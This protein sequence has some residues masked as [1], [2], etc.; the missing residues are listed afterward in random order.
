MRT[1]SVL[2][3]LSS[4]LGA[5][6]V[7]AIVWLIGGRFTLVTTTSAA[8]PVKGSVVRL[9]SDAT[10]IHYVATTGTDDGDCSTPA[11]ACRTIQYAV[12]RAGEGDEVRIATGIYTGVNNYGGL[13]Q[14]VYI[15][16]TVTIRGGYTTTDWITSY[17]ISYPTTLDA[18]GQGRVLYIT[19][20]ISPAVV[21]L[22]ITGGDAAG[23]GGGVGD[24]R[25]EID[26]GGGVY[27]K[28][29]QAD[30]A[31]NWVFSNTAVLGGGLVL[32][33]SDATLEK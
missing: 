23:L 26:A 14:V 28:F 22:R 13:R 12:D 30:F 10:P 2:I 8:G 6:T 17:P 19:G 33:G 4:V 31:N 3:A 5:V 18:Q 15:A 16:E 11:E 21:G 24:P 20:H 1:R 29:A 27:V 25:I 7:L 32:D 9:P